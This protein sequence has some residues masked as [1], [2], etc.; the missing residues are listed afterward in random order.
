MAE[1][2]DRKCRDCQLLPPDPFEKHW[3]VLDANLPTGFQD[4][5]AMSEGGHGKNNTFLPIGI[6]SSC[7]ALPVCIRFTHR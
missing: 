5:E 6:K 7:S 2:I 3:E 1:K 4:S